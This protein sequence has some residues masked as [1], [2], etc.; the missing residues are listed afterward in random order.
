MRGDWTETQVGRAFHRLVVGP[1]SHE[2]Y[3]RMIRDTYPTSL[4]KV[5]RVWVERFG[6][7]IDWTA[8]GL[9]GE[10]VR[11]AWARST[12]AAA[13]KDWRTHLAKFSGAV[14]PRDPLPPLPDPWADRPD[15]LHL[16]LPARVRPVVVAPEDQ[17]ELYAVQERAV[18]LVACARA[19]A[20]EIHA[21]HIT[22]G[23]VCA[24]YG[25]QEP[26]PRLT[27]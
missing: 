5:G 16:E 2:E 7:G 3:R 17:D 10:A 14:L 13:G 25:N 23:R 1:I 4:S 24:G 19:D 22:G 9:Y 11:E 6:S 20:R 26:T 21:E 27:R 12:V 8:T 18:R 15:H